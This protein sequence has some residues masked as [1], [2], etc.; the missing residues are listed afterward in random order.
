VLGEFRAKVQ[1]TIRPED[2]QTHYDLGIAYKEMGLVDEAIA[3]FELAV[4]HGKGGPRAADC[5]LMVGIC[6]AERGRLP[7]AV[8]RFQDGLAFAALAPEARNALSFELGNVLEQLGKRDEALEQY[9]TVERADPR[10]RD[11]QARIVRL[12]GTPRSPA[13]APRAQKSVPAKPAQSAA[14]QPS[15]ND[16]SPAEPDDAKSA[17]AARKA[18]K[19]GFV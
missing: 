6:E 17:E 3:E 1:E 18:R 16:S 11:V 9:A 14:P 2:V 15:Q 12:G 13:A 4:R 5:M 19:I 7:E 10:Y 8:T